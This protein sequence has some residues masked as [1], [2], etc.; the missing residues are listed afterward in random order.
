MRKFIKGKSLSFD[1]NKFRSKL[2]TY[3]IAGLVIAIS[4]AG[5]YIYLNHANKSGYEKYAQ[6]QNLYLQA[7]QE[8]NEKKIENLE[9][10]AQLFKE[11]D[12]QTFWFGSR[13]EV[14]FYLA[15]CLYR[16]NRLEESAYKLKEF[17]EK[18]PESYFSPWANLKLALIYEKIG[19]HEEA[20]DI[21]EVIKEK[22]AL[23]PVA[24]EAFL[25]LARC[26]E[27]IGEEEEAI[28]IYQ[29]LISRYPLSRQAEIAEVKLQYLGQKKG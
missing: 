29:N 20:M 25:G 1:F 23:T 22:Y 14:L 8:E 24:P 15:D 2:K 21:Y 4:V 13:E 18:H 10:A 12:A 16:L 11:L 3:L 26:K 19:S 17:K 28:E 6:A 27:L 5:L 7:L 9:K